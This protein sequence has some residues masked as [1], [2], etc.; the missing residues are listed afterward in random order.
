LLF[1]PLDLSSLPL[2]FFLIS[3]D[4]ALLLLLCLLMAL[5]LIADQST[6]P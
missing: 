4:L 3:V 5:E 6:C 2:K 1:Q